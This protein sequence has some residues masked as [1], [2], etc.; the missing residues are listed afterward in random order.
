MGAIKNFPKIFY[1]KISLPSKKLFFYN[2]FKLIFPK[3]LLFIYFASLTLHT[4]CKDEITQPTPKPPGYQ[5]DIPWPS[6][7]DSPWPMNHHDPQSTGRSAYL[8]P[9]TGNVLWQF[10]GN[11]IQAAPSMGNDS[12]IYFA[13]TGVIHSLDLNGITRWDYIIDAQIIMSPL[14]A[15]DGT[16]YFVSYSANTFLIALNP[17]S[18]LKWKIDLGKYIN[19]FML[20]I[21]LN[22]QLYAAAEKSLFCISPNGQV[23][24]SMEDQRINDGGSGISFSPDGKILFIPGNPVSILAIDIINRSIK[25]TFGDKT[26]SSPPMVDCNG[27]VYFV[28]LSNANTDTISYLY[29]INLSGTLNWKYQFIYPP[30]TGLIL[31]SPTIDK[32]GNIYFATDTLYSISYDGKQNWSKPIKGIC[33]C[34]LISDI[35]SNVYVA[36]QSGIEGKVFLYC[37]DSSGNVKWNLEFI[38]PQVGLSP[39]ITKEEGILFW[40]WRGSNIYY[41][42]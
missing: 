30:L 4:S 11:Y 10:P 3:F 42:K 13:E 36:S 41:I 19:P 38:E 1:K 15:K 24:W 18:S 21:D 40:P 29:S 34:P 5:E 20:N 32:L 12:T 6:L 37:F 17:D 7:A 27:N 23:L 22:G 39:A 33:D 31:K 8:G 35:N 14:I 28:P 26:L 25:W 2:P 9:Q 16:I